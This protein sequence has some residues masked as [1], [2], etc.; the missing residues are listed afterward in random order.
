MA[1]SGLLFRWCAAGLPNTMLVR[2]GVRPV[3]RVLHV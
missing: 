1:L 2:F 3:A